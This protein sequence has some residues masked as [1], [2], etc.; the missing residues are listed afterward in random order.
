MNINFLI[1]IL[2]LNIIF[3]FF[4]NIISV[5]FNLYDHPDFIRK[6]H[7]KKV[8]LAGGFLFFSIFLI[9]FF[10][11]IF[12]ELNDFFT[13]KEIISLTIISSLF[14]F[15]GLFDDKFNL[16]PNSKLILTLITS[17]SLVLFNNNFE[18]NELNF[19]FYSE[20]IKLGNFSVLF[21]IICILCFINACNMFDG[22][23]LQFGFYLILLALFFLSKNLMPVFFLSIIIS[24]IFFLKD[25]YK[26]KIFIGNNGT[27][28][29]GSLFSF[30]FIGAYTKGVISYADEIFLIMAIPGF[31][32][33]RVS[34]L[35]LLKGN[36]MFQPD[37]QH[38]H[39][40]LF[41]TQ[42]IIKTNILIQLSIIFPILLFYF[43]K[44]FLI[45]F[46]ISITMYLWLVIYAKKSTY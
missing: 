9:Y 28:F 2:I 13:N 4:Y 31:D 34:I 33:I 27:L 1:T 43:Y 24:A 41:K 36:H 10:F 40:L 45:S 20:T 44:N 12:F 11:Y 46:V 26:K 16:K 17:L 14:F 6:L 37:N 38:I 7:K 19:S 35:R 32:L 18:I 23:D 15:I 39:H 30:L 5:K 25:N 29:L 3:I 8:S 21:T 22:I 42:S